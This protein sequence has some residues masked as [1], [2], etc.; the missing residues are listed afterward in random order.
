MKKFVLNFN[1]DFEKYIFLRNTNQI[2][3][4]NCIP[5]VVTGKKK[6]YCRGSIIRSK[7]V[8]GWSQNAFSHVI[9]GKSR[10][11]NTAPT[12]M[13]AAT[14]CRSRGAMKIMP[15]TPYKKVNE[16]L[17]ISLIFY[18]MKMQYLRR[19]VTIHVNKK[20]YCYSTKRVQTIPPNKVHF[21]NPP[22]QYHFESFIIVYAMEICRYVADLIIIN[23]K[24]Y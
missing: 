7:P 3:T 10:K 14:D 12:T 22:T 19:L 16:N 6:P 9:L 8:L 2:I 4:L 13:G 17:N 20:V 5:Q 23:Y 11:I 21:C 24:R 15:S 1:R 18:A